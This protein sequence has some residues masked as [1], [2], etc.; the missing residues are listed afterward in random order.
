MNA[1]TDPARAGYERWT[2]MHIG[3]PKWPDLPD[4]QQEKWRL[5]KDDIIEAENNRI[6]ALTSTP[7]LSEIA[8]VHS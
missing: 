8:L 4:W 1:T 7:R 5:V 2:S 6:A 3:A